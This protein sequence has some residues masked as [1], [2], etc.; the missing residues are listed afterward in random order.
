MYDIIKFK[1]IFRSENKL[2]QPVKFMIRIQEMPFS[3]PDLNT[4]YTN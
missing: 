3:N 4:D 1:N 2:A